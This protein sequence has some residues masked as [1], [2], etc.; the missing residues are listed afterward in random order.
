MFSFIFFKK[1]GGV[2]VICVIYLRWIF[3]KFYW[4]GLNSFG[5]YYLFLV[6]DYVVSLLKV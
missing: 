3:F 5:C 4:K 1:G 6:F 2:I